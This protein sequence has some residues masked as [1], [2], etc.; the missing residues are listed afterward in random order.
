MDFQTIDFTNLKPTNIDTYDSILS[1]LLISDEKVEACFHTV[2]DGVAF[3]NYRIL[4]IDV[5]GVTGKKRSI[6]TLPYRK[7]RAYSIETAGVMDFDSRLEVLIN[8]IGEIEFSF[9]SNAD[10][11]EVYRI[12]SEFS[13]K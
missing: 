3:T 10:I 8:G 7:I 11:E 12:I 4:L 2:R 9:T 1:D 5:K 13:L 6:I